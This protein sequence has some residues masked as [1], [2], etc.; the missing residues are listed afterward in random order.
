MYKILSLSGIAIAFKKNHADAKLPIRKHHDDTGMDVSSVEDLVIEPGK[1]AMVDTGLSYQFM[2]NSSP[3]T[4]YI[5]EDNQ[6]PQ[7]AIDPLIVGQV[8]DKNRPVEVTGVL[9]AE[10]NMTYEIQVRPR[11]GLAAKHGITV[12]NA[13]GSIDF[14]YRGP[15]KVI[16][17]NLGTE[18]FKIEKGDRIAQL[19]ISQTFTFPIVELTKEVTAT[20]RGAEG[21]GSTGV[22]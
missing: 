13:P 1:I 18:P 8:H 4:L 17:M 5:D 15:I 21:F 20:D 6:V 7:D 12:L 19:V 2:Y 10:N 11:S 16:L 22:K 3:E 14:S 9:H